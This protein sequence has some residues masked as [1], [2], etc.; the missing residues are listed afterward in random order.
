MRKL[1]KKHLLIT[2]IP[3]IIIIVGIFIF[4]PDKTLE[5]NGKKKLQ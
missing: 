1:N 4:I 3:I 5:L 2:I